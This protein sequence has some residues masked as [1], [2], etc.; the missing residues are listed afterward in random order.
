MTKTTWSWIGQY[1]AVLVLI[2]FAGPFL[3]HLAAFQSLTI[4]PLGLKGSH[5]IR[6]LVDGIALS[7]LWWLSFKTSRRLED[8]GRGLAFL[9][10]TLLPA[11]TLLVLILADRALRGAG[12]PLL[13]RA[14]YRPYQWGH[15]AA[16]LAAGI[17]LSA[18]WLARLPALRAC[19]TGP[20]AHKAVNQKPATSPDP[21]DPQEVNG[22][23]V[24]IANDGAPST[25]GR[26]KIL[27]ELG[28]GAMGVVYLGKDPTI[29]R[30][31]AIKTMR[32]DE[33]DDADEMQDV[34]ARFFREAEST[35]RLSHPNI[36]TV[37]DAGEEHD[38]GYIAMEL[39]D[40]TPLKHWSRP[41]N[42]MPP[43]D[44]I[45]VLSTVAEA[46]D[47]A[48]QQGIVHRDVKPANIMVTKD[49]IVK[50]TDFG[51][52]KMASS[53]KTQTNI[54]LGTPSYMSP[55]QIA[56]KRVDGR[57]DIF[58]LGVVLYELLSGR[59]PFTAD[60][61]PAL[62]F[63]VAHHPHTSIQVLCPDL[64]SP[65][66]DIVNRALHKEALHRYR[67]AGEMAQDLRACLQNPAYA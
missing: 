56:G 30:F 43:K 67:R 36:V 51:I 13:E 24:T 53:S 38:L 22:R 61:L 41:P 44:V 1:G 37:Y 6:L 2:L 9:R 39:L 63:A 21:P 10:G 11:T 59:L 35:G 23:T 57:S 60:N 3:G 40:G 15:A 32:L 54:V 5:A 19:F 47:Y 12:F 50:V 49:H 62:L 18:A 29:Q 48:H 65:V 4:P 28:R 46:L 20:Q 42:L 45:T 8:N 33:V 31:V 25:L 34:K 64:P 14:G 66:V 55:E 17:W 27:K 26:Y 7:A 58:S 16:L 52:A